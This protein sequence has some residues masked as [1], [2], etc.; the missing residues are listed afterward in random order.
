MKQFFVAITVLGIIIL[1][2]CSHQSNPTT[3]KETHKVRMTTYVDD[4]MPLIQAKCS[5]CHLPSK[6][7]PKLTLKHILQPRNGGQKW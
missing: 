3:V 4:V 5:P 6:E 7:D 1:A 2:A